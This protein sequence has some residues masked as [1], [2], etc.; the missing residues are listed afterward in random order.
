MR[1]HSKYVRMQQGDQECPPRLSPLYVCTCRIL[2][3]L[4]GSCVKLPLAKSNKNTFK[5]CWTFATCQDTKT[6]TQKP[7]GL[8]K[9]LRIPKRYF[10]YITIDCL[11]LSPVRDSTT[12][13]QYSYLWVIVNRFSKYTIL[14]ALKDGYTALIL[15]D[16]IMEVVCPVFG[17]PMDIVSH[18]ETLFCSYI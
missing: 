5:Y 8:L 4:P 17:L 9:P 18:Q 13:S 3:D 2:Q 12:R 6:S 10:S 1:V 15:K 14:I 7:T 16:L 11:Y